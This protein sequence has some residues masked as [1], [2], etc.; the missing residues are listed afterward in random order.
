[1]RVALDTNILVY[2]EGL[3]EDPKRVIA[4]SLLRAGQ[5]ANTYLPV[6]VLGEFFNVL[7][8]KG[9]DSPKQARATVLRWSDQYPLL[10]TSPD[11]LMSAL[12]LS[13]HHHLRIWDAIIIAAASSA[14]C[15]LL[16]SEDLQ[17]GFTWSG[18]TVVNPF[19]KKPNELLRTLLGF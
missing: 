14:G 6:Q 12:D 19:A 13:T 8:R 9:G 17:D 7:A 10:E 1:M 3:N 18:C 15:R 5:T 2:A 16:L 4:L 11:V